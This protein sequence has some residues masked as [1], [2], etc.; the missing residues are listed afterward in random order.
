[1]YIWQHHNNTTTQQEQGSSLKTCQEGASFL[2]IS[3]CTFWNKCRSGEIP[4]IRL[5]ARCYR[6]RQ[7]DLESFINSR[8]RWKQNTANLVDWN[9]PKLKRKARGSA[10]WPRRPRRGKSLGV[11]KINRGAPAKKQNGTIPRQR[12]R[13]FFEST[14]QWTLL[15]KRRMR[16]TYST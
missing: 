4:H 13:P 2:G 3:K 12:N 16:Q 11:L 9:G 5:S 15:S 1:M 14:I 10:P 6:V 7:S 8:T